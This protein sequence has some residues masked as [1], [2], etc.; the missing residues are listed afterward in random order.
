MILF[1]KYNYV[2]N[3]ISN[4]RNHC[5]HVEKLLCFLN[6]DNS[7]ANY[8]NVMDNESF[9]VVMM[10]VII[11]DVIINGILSDVVMVLKTAIWS[12]TRIML[13]GLGD[14]SMVQDLETAV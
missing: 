4:M 9:I 10:A 7:Q 11:R 2:G 14:C 6:N 5:S 13:N 8:I 12:R 3:F 1:A